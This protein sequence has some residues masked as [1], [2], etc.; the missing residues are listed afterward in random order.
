MDDIHSIQELFFDVIKKETKA[1]F[2]P[3][4]RK[5]LRIEIAHR[6]M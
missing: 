3:T 4:D 5:S 2:Q 1:L 6:L